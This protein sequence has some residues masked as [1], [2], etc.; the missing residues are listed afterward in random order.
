MM[1]FFFQRSQSIILKQVGLNEKT[2]PDEVEVSL[3]S[4]VKFYGNQANA[5]MLGADVIFRGV[6][7]STLECLDCHHSS[8]STEPFLDLSLPL[9]VDK[10]QPPA[11][12]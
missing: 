11:L 5:K 7:V 2:N 8:Q 3:K 10:P 4:R 12:G 6:L 1:L 9:T